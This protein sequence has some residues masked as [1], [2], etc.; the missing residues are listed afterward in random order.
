MTL[1]HRFSAP[2]LALARLLLAQHSH[3]SDR[4]FNLK[5]TNLLLLCI[6]PG[7]PGAGKTILTSILVEELTSRFHDNENIGIAYLYCNFRRREE[8]NKN[9]LLASLLKQLARHQPILPEVVKDLYNRHDAQRTRPSFDEISRSLQSTIAMY[10]RVFIVIDALDECNVSDGSRTTFLS[11]LFSLQTKCTVNLF[12]TSRFG[13]EFSAIFS[14]SL[15]LEIRASEHDVRRFLDGHILAL[16]G[17]VRRSLDLQEEVKGEIVKAVDGMFLLAKL[18][19]DSLS[20]KKSLKALRTALKNLPSGSDAYDSAYKDAMVR[21]EGQIADEEELAKQV[22]SWITCAKRPLTTTELQHAL[23]IETGES[24]L[25]QDNLPDIE[26]LVTVCAGLVTV[27]EQSNIIRLVH[28]TTQEYFRRS[29]GQWFPGAEANITES[30]IAYLSFEMFLQG[31]CQTDEEFEERVQSNQLFA[32]AA[33]NWGHH[34]CMAVTSDHDLGVTV[35]D[36]L[37]KE[38]NVSASSQG[39]FAVKRWSGDSRYSQRTP[40][41]I[42][43]VHLAAYFGIKSVVQLLLDNAFEADSQDTDGQTPLSWAAE[44]GHETVVKL[45]LKTDKVEA[46]SKDNNGQTPLSWAAS[47]G[48][49]AVVKLLLQTGEVEADSKDNNGQTPLSWAAEKGHEAVVKLLLQTDKVEADPK[50][51]KTDKVEADSKDNNG[52]T[53]LSW[54]AENGHEAVVKLLLQTG[55]VEVDSKDNKYGQTPLSWAAE[56]GHEAVVKLLLQTDKVEADS[57]DNNGRTSLS[58]AAENGHETVVKLLLETDK[59][60]ADSKDNNSQ[61]PLSFAAENG[62]EA[63]V[64]L[65]LLNNSDCAIESDDGWAVMELAAFNTHNSVEQ[66]LVTCGIP[67]PED[68]YGLQSMFLGN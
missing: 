13:T 26:D 52:R 38:A 55:E 15:S 63:V 10:S 14:N 35:A 33:Q 3:T 47:R 37:K 32:Y 43:G 50:D 31:S 42:T 59:V 17:F 36:F 56:N 30:C 1:A 8:Q 46:D 67:E 49:E 24:K 18:H 58:F 5:L 54:A 12:A 64:K 27:D 45:L 68:L 7:I 23:A 61:T 2:L 39:L 51:N 62:H 48:H 34:G 16:P 20:G 65:L 44:N 22:L 66:L 6:L 60:E 41:N 11:E 25:D 57:K 21:I 4:E 40:K 9:N 19:L 28:Y 53:S 29:Q